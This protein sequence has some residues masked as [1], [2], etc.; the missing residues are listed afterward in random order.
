MRPSVLR[1]LVNGRGDSQNQPVILAWCHLDPIGVAHAEPLLRD[2]RYGLPAAV[3]SILV[4]DDVSLDVQV[5][6]TPHVDAVPIAKRGYHRLLDCGD[7]LAT[8]F[9]VHRVFHAEHFLL[10]P[11][12]LA[13]L[14]IL[15]DECVTDTEC[16]TVDLVDALTALVL[17]E[18]VVTDRDE[19]LA[20]L[21]AIDRRGCLLWSL[22][23]SPA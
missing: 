3:D 8:A 5:W 7:D 12:Q 6:T 1:H 15:H 4:V 22:H 21:I 9:D 19:L 20:H 2:F 14:Q 17:D 18:V 23:S 11:R 13:P 10:N 16:L